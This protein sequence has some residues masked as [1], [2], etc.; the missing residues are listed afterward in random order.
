MEKGTVFDI[1]QFAVHDGPGIRTTIFFKGCP[2]NCWWCHNPEGLSSEIEIFYYSSRCMNCENCVKVCPAE[3]IVKKEHGIL[4]LR[5]RCTM[6][7]KC[8][9]TCPT[10]SLQ[11]VGSIVT[12]ET[13]IKEIKKYII[14][15]NASDGGVTFSGGE[16]LMQPELLTAIV[17]ECNQLGVHTTLDTSGYAPSHTFRSVAEGI[18]L[19]LYDLKIMDGQT[20]MKYTGVSNDAIINNLKYLVDTGRGEDVII[21]FPVI[22]GITDTENNVNDIVGFVSSLDDVKKIDLLPFH[23]VEEKYKRLGKKYRI[24]DIV[25]PS[26]NTIDRVRKEFEEKGFTVRVGG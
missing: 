3:A 9:E 13:M 7:G 18:D 14:Y 8:V 10:G 21:R 6:C 4:L 5:E 11:M 16:P 12:A 1:K 15:Y 20:H 23:K 26:T 24:T 19:F 25:S 22:T 2:L 17:H